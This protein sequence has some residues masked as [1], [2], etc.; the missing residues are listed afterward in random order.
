MKTVRPTVLIESRASEITQHN[1]QESEA[2]H[3]YYHQNSSLYVAVHD[4]SLLTALFNFVQKI[5]FLAEKRWQL[6]TVW[7]DLML[8]IRL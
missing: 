7:L 1:A 6:P 2:D 4:L 5:G 3:K 8:S